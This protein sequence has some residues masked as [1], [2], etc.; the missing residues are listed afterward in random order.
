MLMPKP[1]VWLQ[2]RGSGEGGPGAEEPRH[3]VVDVMCPDVA[4]DSSSY[5]SCD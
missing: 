4:R 3:C 5:F 2:E 1:S